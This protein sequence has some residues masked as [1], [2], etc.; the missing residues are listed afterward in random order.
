MLTAWLLQAHHASPVEATARDLG[1][2][3]VLCP[4]NAR[5]VLNCECIG[6]TQ[7]SA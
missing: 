6:F 7:L 5:E 3:N 4:P 1:V 2:P